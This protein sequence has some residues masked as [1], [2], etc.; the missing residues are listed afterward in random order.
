MCHVAFTTR[1]RRVTTGWRERIREI[2][3]HTKVV[4]L[5]SAYSAPYP[6]CFTVKIFNSER[7]FPDVYVRI[8]VLLRKE[9]LRVGSRYRRSRFELEIRKKERDFLRKFYYKYFKKILVLYF[10]LKQARNFCCVFVTYTTKVM[11]EP[12]K[13]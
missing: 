13:N 5:I 7:V 6:T 3:R 8:L 2:T 9:N 1:L 4:M 11:T 12:F 10:C